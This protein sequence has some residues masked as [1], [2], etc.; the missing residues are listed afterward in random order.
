MSAAARPRVL[1]VGAGGQLGGAASA[2]LAETC[3]V[4]ALARR[5]LDI[6]DAGAVE[7][8]VRGASPDIV[9]NCSAYNR[10]DDA[11]REVVEA[12]AVNA[13]GVLSLGR[14]AAEAGAVF[15]HYSTDFVFDGRG[16]RP[17]VEEDRPNPLS[18][19]GMSKLL[20]ELLV[21]ALP[22]TYVLRVESLFGGLRAKSTLDRIV[23][24][25]AA[26]EDVRVFVD[27]T[28]TPSYVHDVVDATR[29][30][31]E[32]G[33]APGTYHVVNSGTAT[34]EE[35]ALEAAR[36]MGRAP[37]LVRARMSETAL[38]APRPLYCALSNAK[39]ARA[40]VAMPPWQD[41]LARHLRARGL[42]AAWIS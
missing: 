12:L 32:R 36:L 14:A 30:L 11:E 19:Y 37:R 24:G 6:R 4:V 16:A 17:Y 23:D 34:W 5:D 35:I 29:A 38:P 31:V 7:R 33:A 21:R 41:A 10:V 15:V 39:L 40:G 28:V 26:G 18:A 2:R 3:E 13:V 25:I 9:L 27:R 8:A 20:G 22:R 1:V 42:A